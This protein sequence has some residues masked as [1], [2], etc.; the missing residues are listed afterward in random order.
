[1]TPQGLVLRDLNSTN[2]TY[3]DGIRLVGETLINPDSLIQFADH[4]FRLRRQENQSPANTQHEDVYDH[5][6]ALVQ[7][8]RLMNERAVVPAYQPIVE[9]PS[10]RIVGFEV[11]GRSRIVGL[12]SSQKMFAAATQLSLEVELSRMLRWEGIQS[13]EAFPNRPCLFVNTHPEELRKEGLIESMSAVR[14]AY[15]HQEI[16]LEIHEGAISVPAQLKRLRQQLLDLNVRLAFD[17]F[18]AGQARLVELAEVKP[19]VL[20]FDMSLV[21]GLDQRG[22]QRIQMVESLVRIAT[23]LGTIPLAEGIETEGEKRVCLEIGFK[24]AQGFLFGRPAPSK[25]HSE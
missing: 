23:D 12:E 25:Y 5:A 4:A 10:E 22:D 2:G 14:E 8:D 16:T 6:L 21:R 3:V 1:M 20:K 7:F 17:D 15:P 11:L 18:G 19:D 9:F 13:A 24:L